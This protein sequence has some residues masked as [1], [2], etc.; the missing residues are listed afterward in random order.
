MELRVNVHSMIDVITNSSTEIF[1]IMKNNAVKGM[2]EIIDEILKVGES[3]YKATDLF[4]VNLEHDYTRIAENFVQTHSKKWKSDKRHEEFPN[5]EVKV[6]MEGVEAIKEKAGWKYTEMSK[7][8]KD[9]IIPYILNN[10]EAM[11]KYSYYEG[12][13]GYSGDEIMVDSW[14]VVKAKNQDKSTMDIWNKITNLFDAE[15]VEN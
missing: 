9:K 12:Y 5:D 6:L 11:E 8:F 14:L 2:F 4:T 13:G 3:G 10:E 1:L 15:E 7:Y